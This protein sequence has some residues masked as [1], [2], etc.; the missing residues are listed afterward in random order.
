MESFFQF[1]GSNFFIVVIVLLGIYNF[2]RSFQKKETKSEEQRQPKTVPSRGGSVR[3]QQS[4]G[5]GLGRMAEQMERSL[6]DVTKHFT[7]NSEMA[8]KS[9]QQQQQAQYDQ[10]KKN[11]AAEYGSQSD[12]AETRSFPVSS[13]P[14]RTE[15]K[16]IGKDL[17][18]QDRLTSSGLI[19]SVIMAEVLGAPRALNPYQNIAK[20]RSR[21]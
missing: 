20:R 11:I 10:L 4:R 17:H 18:L 7:D 14:Y 8:A 1:I 9:L 6:K 5:Q 19:E 15:N 2:L 21:R 16:G 13:N 12:K 3:P